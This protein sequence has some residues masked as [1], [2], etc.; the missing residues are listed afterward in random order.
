MASGNAWTLRETVSVP[1]LAVRA[2]SVLSDTQ[3]AERERERDSLCPCTFGVCFVVVTFQ[4]SFVINM[5][6]G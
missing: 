1:R 3:S 5:N 6:G 2:L 4:I